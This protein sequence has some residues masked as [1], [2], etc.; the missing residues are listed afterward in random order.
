[1]VASV[2]E[3]SRRRRPPQKRIVMGEINIVSQPHTARSYVEAIK[4]LCDQRVQVPYHGQ[5]FIEFGSCRDLSDPR[6]ADA[7]TGRLFVFSKFN[8]QDPWLNIARNAQ[9]T[10]E[11]LAA[12][13][14]PAHLVPEFR[15][16]RYIFDVQ[17]HTLYFEKYSTTKGHLSTRAFAIILSFGQISL[18]LLKDPV[19]AKSHYLGVVASF[20]HFIIMQSLALILAIIGKAWPTPIIGVFGCIAFVY[21]IAL[22]VAAAMRLFRLARIYNQIKAEAVNDKRDGDQT[23]F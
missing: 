21:A 20:V 23:T 9:A 15:Y 7:L 3:G 8:F 10:D 5:R 4:L 11:E 12:I 6:L 19:E 2:R 13:K 18:D 14:I 1:M 17:R 22:S 16:F